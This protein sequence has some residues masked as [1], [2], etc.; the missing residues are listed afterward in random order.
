MHPSWRV[1]KV[2]WNSPQ[3]YK[4]PAPLWQAVIAGGWSLTLTATS[5]H[6]AVG[7]QL[8]LDSLYLSG[9][10]AHTHLGVYESYKALYSI[11]DGLNL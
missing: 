4:R 5:V 11:Q 9:C 6:S 10:A 2:S 8:D 3:R 1:E 7:L